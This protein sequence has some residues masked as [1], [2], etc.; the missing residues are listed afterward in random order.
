METLFKPKALERAIE[1]MVAAGGSEARE[2]RLVAENL[3]GL[4]KSGGE[5]QDD[6]APGRL[7]DAANAL[8]DQTGDD[9]G[10]REFRLAAVQDQRLT[11]PQ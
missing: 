10:L 9:V 1:A 6:A 5:G 2:A 8:A 4:A 3:V 11:A 7:G